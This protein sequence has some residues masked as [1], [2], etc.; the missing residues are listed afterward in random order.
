[1][2]KRRY[3]KR[4]YKK[5]AWKKRSAPKK[6]VSFSKRVSA[7]VNKRVLES[8]TYQYSDVIPLVGIDQTVASQ[9]FVPLSPFGGYVDITQGTGQGERVGNKLRI[10]KATLSFVM[11]PLP[12]NETT[13][14]DP[15]PLEIDMILFTA[16]EVPQTIWS[17]TAMS[18]FFQLGNSVAAPTGNLLD[19][20]RTVNSDSYT[21]RLRRQFKLGY[22][23][24]ILAPANNT[25]ANYV[26]NDFKYNIRQ[27]I[28]I[29]K[30]LVK[31]VRFQDNSANAVSHMTQMWVQAVYAD[32]TQMDAGSAGTIPG[33][34]QYTISVEYTDA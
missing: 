32:N 27:T 33:E 5:R 4:A 9:T 26:N 20:T 8:K 23:S 7:I 30:H 13:N 10:K 17:P 29:T 21:M 3:V 16:K 22:G 2:A 34:M 25:N 14:A 1:M 12:Y 24:F 19:L 31:N 15:I 6:K 18:D 28:D 11:L